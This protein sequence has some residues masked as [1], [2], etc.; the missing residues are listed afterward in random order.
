MT[1]RIAVVAMLIALAVMASL[2]DGGATRERAAGKPSSDAYLVQSRTDMIA[3][4]RDQGAPRSYCECVSDE[5]LERNGRNVA[6]L[7]AMEAELNRLRPGSP[8][9]PLLVKATQACAPA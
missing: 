4:C 1:G 9:P 8:P 7:Q 5:V 2:A 3:G 6:R